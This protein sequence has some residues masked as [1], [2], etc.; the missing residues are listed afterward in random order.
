MAPFDETSKGDG[1]RAE[2]SEPHSLSRAEPRVRIHSPPVG[3]QARTV[4]GSEKARPLT[5]PRA[6]AEELMTAPPVPG[7]APHRKAPNNRGPFR[8]GHPSILAEALE[9][10]GAADKIKVA[11]AIRAMNLTTGPA[12]QCF[13]GPIKFDE[14]GRRVDVPMIFAQ[15]QKGVPITVFPTN[16]ALATAV[17][18]SV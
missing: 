10:C 4:D 16:L 8:Y 5:P 15:W 6:P 18:P 9:A 2:A 11:E 17:W 3:S 14:K 13:P 7:E 12:A 1:E